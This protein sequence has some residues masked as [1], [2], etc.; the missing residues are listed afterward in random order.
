MAHSFREA[1]VQSAMAFL[2]VAREDAELA[3]ELR[4]LD[5][6]DGLGPVLELAAG[7]GFALTAEAL[8][9]AHRLDW[10]LRSAHHA[11]SA[12]ASAASTVAVVKNASSST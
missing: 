12:R 2:R 1:D 3:A 6:D 7:A 5:P 11:A 8:R 9:E 4:A 10:Q